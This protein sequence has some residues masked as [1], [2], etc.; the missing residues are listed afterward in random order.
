MQEKHQPR[1]DRKRMQY[2]LYTLKVLPYFQKNSVS[3]NHALL[4]KMEE[5]TGDLS[6]FS[7]QFWAANAPSDR[8][9]RGQM[10]EILVVYSGGG[11]ILCISTYFS[12]KDCLKRV[13][14]DS[15]I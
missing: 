12:G 8:K 5:E 10:R 15:E 1:I 11:S 13:R 14:F 2:L 9:V 6:H 4:Q 7:F 3:T